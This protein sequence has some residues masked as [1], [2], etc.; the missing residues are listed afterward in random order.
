MS[1]APKVVVRRSS[2][3]LG[4]FA[5]APFAKGD[6]VIEYTGEVITD[7]EAQR[8]GGKYLFELNDQWTIDGKGRKNIARYIN[9]SCKPNCYPELTEDEKQVLIHAKRK[10]A[11]G[12][13]LTYNYGADYFKRVIKPHGCRCTKCK[14]TV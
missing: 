3:G 6:L 7:D 14:T 12:E 8:R 5:A 10:I 13:E 9:H 2:A 1:E 11:P 4:L